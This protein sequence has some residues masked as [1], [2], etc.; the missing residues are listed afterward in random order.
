[1]GVT[2]MSWKQLSWIAIMIKIRIDGLRRPDQDSGFL[3]GSTSISK[4]TPSMRI[5]FLFS[6]LSSHFTWITE[7]DFNSS[8]SAGFPSTVIFAA[9][10]SRRYFVLS[11]I[12]EIRMSFS[13][14]DMESRRHMPDSIAVHRKMVPV[15]SRQII[16]YTKPFMKTPGN[17]R[18]GLARSFARLFKS[19]Q[20]PR[21]K[22]FCHGYILL[23]CPKNAESS[24]QAS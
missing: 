22:A 24:T 12:V 10:I 20:N 19:K 14:S 7:K 16:K 3:G 2:G 11:G 8:N 17:M 13:D 9:E 5:P 21:G 4:A 23:R 1:M 18:S 15:A 6:S